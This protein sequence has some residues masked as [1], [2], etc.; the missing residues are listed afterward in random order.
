VVFSSQ[1]A[2]LTDSVTLGRRFD[3]SGNPLGGTFYLS[4]KEVPNFG[5]PPAAASNPRIA[6]RNGNVAIVWQSGSYPYAVIA[7]V[8]AQRYFQTS[9]AQPIAPSLSISGNNNSVTIS[10]P[11]SVTGYTLKSSASLASGATWTAVPGVANNTVTIANPAGT[12]FYRLEQ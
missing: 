8:V 7:P 4:E 10:W 5:T 1:I 11:A 2:G 12:Q 6:W 3:A 9:I